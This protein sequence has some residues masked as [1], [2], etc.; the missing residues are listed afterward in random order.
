M[1]TRL[2]IVVIVVMGKIAKIPGPQNTPGFP[3]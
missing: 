2:V 1:D 3:Q